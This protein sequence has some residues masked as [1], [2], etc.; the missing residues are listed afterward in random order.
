M[1]YSIYVFFGD[2]KFWT[3]GSRKVLC[4]KVS[5][6]FFLSTNPRFLIENMVEDI[7]NLILNKYKNLTIGTTS[8]YKL[9]FLVRNIY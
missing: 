8:L 4:I 7:D 9:Y 2:I 1:I 3:N 6:N 5:K